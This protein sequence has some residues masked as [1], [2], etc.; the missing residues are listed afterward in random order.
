M[1]VVSKCLDHWKNSACL[2]Y[3]LMLSEL[4]AITDIVT[5]NTPISVGDYCLKVYR[6]I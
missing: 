4:L 1:T 3:L 5:Q 6:N 2:L